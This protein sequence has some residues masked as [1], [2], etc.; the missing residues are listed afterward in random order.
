[1]LAGVEG[2]EIFLEGRE[3]RAGE[4][5]EVEPL[6][7]GG[8]FWGMVGRL[9]G[10]PIGGKADIDIVL[11]LHFGEVNYAQEADIFDNYLGAGFF[12]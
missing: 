4:I 3:E 11:G 10:H 8:F 1:M 6:P 7:I 5:V 9:A 2:Y 12:G